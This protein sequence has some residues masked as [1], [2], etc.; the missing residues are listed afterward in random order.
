MTENTEMR[1]LEKNK[2]EFF[3]YSTTR[4]RNSNNVLYE[5]DDK[6]GV[7]VFVCMCVCARAHTTYPQ[8]YFKF[9]NIFREWKNCV[10]VFCLGD[11]RSGLV[12]I[13]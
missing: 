12:N 13:F 10:E 8:R 1:L 6:S 11:R 2:N 7:T 5:S 3:A 9:I 4:Y